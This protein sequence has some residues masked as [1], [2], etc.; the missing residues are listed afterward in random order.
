MILAAL[1]QWCGINVI[2]YYAE[3]VFKAAGYTVSGLMVNIVFT[4][5]INL[6]FTFVA[7]FTVDKL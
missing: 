3:D 5:L 7:I 1:Q 6:I 2:F 4:G